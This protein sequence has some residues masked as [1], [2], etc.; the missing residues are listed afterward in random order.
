MLVLKH[1]LRVCL[2]G[3]YVIDSNGIPSGNGGAL[4]K[5]MLEMQGVHI[6]EC[7]REIKNVFSFLSAYVVLAIKHSRLQYDI[8][9]IPWRGILTLPLAKVICRKPMVHFPAFSI[10]DTLVNDRKKVSK[11][12]LLAKV[13]HF[14]DKVACKWVDQIILESNEEIEYFMREFKLP[15]N[16]FH[17]LYLSADEFIFFPQNNINND[18]FT[19]LFFGTFIPLHG[20]GTIVKTANLLKNEDILFKLCGDGQTR[21]EMEGMVKSNGLSNVSFLGLV[22]KEELLDNIHSSDVCLGIFGNTIKSKKVLT[23][24]V[25]QILACEKPLITMDSQT[26]RE[27]HLKHELNCMLISPSSPKELAD[28]ILNLK[29]NP[30]KRKSITIE[31]RKTFEK[32]FSLNATG[33][34]LL[35]YLKELTKS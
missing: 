2:F 23:N 32:Y 16:K 1:V 19:V 27:A 9:I 25:Y 24:K 7:H 15:R 11:K 3:S 12:S 18:K 29:N 34:S 20:V 22:S 31:G 8:M 21:K 26:A 30:E 17:Q 35:D 14:I 5:K 10:Y 33:R 6:V 4:I 28:A 13:I